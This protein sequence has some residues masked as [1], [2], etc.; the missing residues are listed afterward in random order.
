M[1]N[2]V[3]EV[4]LNEKDVI[5]FQKAH[6]AKLISPRMRYAIIAVVAVLFL[7]NLILDIISG[8][9]I[10]MTA[11]MLFVILIVILG[12]PILLR[13][14]AKSSLKSNKMLMVKQTYTFTKDTISSFSDISSLDTKWDKMNEFRES[15][16]HF[17]FYI[18]RNQA[19]LVPKS[20]ME[21]DVSKM[22]FI[23]E[24]AKAI[25]SPEKK[26]S[27]FKVVMTVSLVLT[28]IMFVII[29][30]LTLIK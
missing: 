6:Y 23:R 25:P 2:V 29:V 12:T 21:N 1:D 22:A 4:E 8:K 19:F 11:G 28:V 14:N 10:S 27:L 13:M 16:N 18:G 26:F 7:V 24:C 17:L 30:I 5:E 15:K 20:C 3:V 9:Y